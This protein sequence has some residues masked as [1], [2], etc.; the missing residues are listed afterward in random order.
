MSQDKKSNQ[1][2]SELGTFKAGDLQKKSGT[3]KPA[4]AKSSEQEANAPSS[5]YERVE[6]LIENY[7][8]ADE[9]KQVFEETIEQLRVRLSEE[10]NI[11]KKAEINKALQAFKNTFEMLDYLFNVKNELITQQLGGTNK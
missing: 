4:A 7:A 10:K 11:K 9:A 3:A 8:T 2:A 1:T 5:N 6:A